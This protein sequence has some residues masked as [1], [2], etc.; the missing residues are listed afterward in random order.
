MTVCAILVC[1][2]RCDCCQEKNCVGVRRFC[3][4]T[5]IMQRNFIDRMHKSY[6]TNNRCGFCVLSV[7]SYVERKPVHWKGSSHTHNNKEH[8]L[9]LIQAHSY[10]RL[11]PLVNCLT[12]VSCLAAPS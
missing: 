4:S 8:F 1:R 3:F 10:R 5:L 11:I 7:V 6:S 2:K 12:S 9:C